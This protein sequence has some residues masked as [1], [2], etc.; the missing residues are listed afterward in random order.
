MQQPKTHLSL[1]VLPTSHTILINL[2]T[3][4]SER[5]H[6]KSSPMLRTMNH[7]LPCRICGLCFLLKCVRCFRWA[8]FGLWTGC[9]CNQLSLSRNSPSRQQGYRHMSPLFSPRLT[10]SFVRV[11][12]SRV[13]AVSPP[14]GH[15]SPSVITV[16]STVSWWKTNASSTT[17]CLSK[18]QKTIFSKI[19]S[20]T[21]ARDPG[22]ETCDVLNF[23]LL[24]KESWITVAHSRGFFLNLLI[25]R[26]WGF[27][28]QSF[29]MEIIGISWTLQL[30]HGLI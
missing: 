6:L 12:V 16:V 4:L 17:T 29:Q 11:Q 25:I 20:L 26:L 18:R 19:I 14:R 3:R 21:R 30:I 22:K 24:Q 9:L 28:I 8:F 27:C 1:R 15:H 13:P 7:D 5:S 23:E 2:S 10:R